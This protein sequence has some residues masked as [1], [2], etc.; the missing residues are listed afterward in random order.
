MY[1][2][3]QI[4]AFYLPQFHQIPENDQFWGE[5]FTDWVTV[6]KAVP[7]YN[8]HQQPKIP[9]E[10]NY[11]DLSIAENVRWQTDLAANY[12]VDGFGVYHYWFH[13][14]KNLLAKPAEIMR[15]MHKMKIKY[16]LVWDNSSWKRSWSNL[17]GNDWAPTAD[18]LNGNPSGP[19]IL[20]PYI[21]GDEDDW[22]EHYEVVLSH[23]KSENYIKDGNKPMFLILG[24]HERIPEMCK[25]WDKWARQDGYEGVLFIFRNTWKIDK[26]IYRY[27]YEPHTAGW[28]MAGFMM[29]CVNKFCKI[30][31][32]QQGLRRYNYDK[33]WRRLLMKAKTCSDKK[34]FYGGFVSY[35]DTP[36]RGK[37]RSKVVENGSPQKFKEYLTELLKISK[38]QEKGYVFLTAWNEWGEGAYLEPDVHSGFSNLDAIRQ[39]RNE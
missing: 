34:L 25:C 15:D 27:N 29:R 19:E 32:L 2:S 23:F 1:R 39:S 38:S 36:R 28:D 17:S 12:G 37:C 35:D 31:K 10:D 7:F 26:S 20:I 11:Y 21:L 8:G 6:K 33:I 5:G 4:I 13:R 3:P 14:G 22:R 30:L 9:S 24:Y 16:C 18:R